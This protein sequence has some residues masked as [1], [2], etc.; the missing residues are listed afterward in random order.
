MNTFYKEFTFFTVEAVKDEYTIHFTAYNGVG[1]LENFEEQIK[2]GMDV[3][4]KEIIALTNDPFNDPGPLFMCYIKWDGCSNWDFSTKENSSYPIHFCS[5]LEAFHFGK[6]IGDLY[7][8]AA[9]LSPENKEYI[10]FKKTDN[11]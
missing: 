9:E 1:Y 3:S 6:M 4:I 10:L 2:L 11:L 7:E 5:S 8:W